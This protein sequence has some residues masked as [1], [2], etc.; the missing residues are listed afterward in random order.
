MRLLAMKVLR[1]AGARF[2]GQFQASGMSHVPG[3]ASFSPRDHLM[4]LS[5]TTLLS[6]LLTFSGR[7]QGVYTL[8]LTTTNNEGTP[9]SYL[10]LLFDT[11][12]ATMTFSNTSHI[13][14]DL[15]ANGSFV[16]A[17]TNYSFDGFR[18]RIGFPPNRVAFWLT[19]STS[20]D[21]LMVNFIYAFNPFPD[22]SVASGMWVLQNTNLT[23]SAMTLT[24]NG[25]NLEGISSFNLAG[26]PEPSSVMLAVAGVASAL[27]WRGGVSRKVFCRSTRGNA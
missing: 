20:A 27:L 14:F 3:S 8:T 16:D 11:S 18:M 13:I 25:S 15:P 2:G 19:N 9:L 17:G 22:H 1:V 4:M 26:T 23:P 6:L 24:L 12:L 21:Y 7:A 5:I 10:S